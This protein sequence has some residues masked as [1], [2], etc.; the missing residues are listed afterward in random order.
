MFISQQ[1]KKSRRDRQVETKQYYS[2]KKKERRQILPGVSLRQIRGGNHHLGSWQTLGMLSPP[3][4]KQVKGFP[5]TNCEIKKKK[6]SQRSERNA[7]WFYFLQVISLKLSHL[8]V[9][10][11]IYSPYHTY[12]V[13]CRHID[14]ISM[15][16]LCCPAHGHMLFT[17]VLSQL[18]SITI[19][20]NTNTCTSVQQWSINN[21]SNN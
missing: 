15:I 9:G 16:L 14:Q 4:Q 19:C 21:N 8:S 3:L 13:M 10:F 2:L 5:V 17:K 18:H 12:T 1:I 7:E 20:C 11:C 6:R